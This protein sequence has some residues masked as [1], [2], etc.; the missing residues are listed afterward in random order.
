MKDELK[1][2]IY[3][4][5]EILD[6]AKYLLED[7]RNEA[8]VNRAY[9]AMFTIVNGLLLDKDVFVKTHTGVKAKFHEYFLK[10]NLLRL[11][12]G[13]AYENA[14]SLRQEADYDFDMEI[15]DEDAR[16]TIDDADKFIK[17]IILFLSDE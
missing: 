3:K 8:A 11:E 7:N 17:E 14:F 16:Q 10:T 4:S 9:Y 13:K 1:K 12:L 15:S 2:I 6:D 5:N